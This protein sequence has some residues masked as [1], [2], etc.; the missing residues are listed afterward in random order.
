VPFT[1]CLDVTLH[2]AAVPTAAKAALRLQAEFIELARDPHRWTF[3]YVSA[4]IEGDTL[5]VRALLLEP[6]ED[7]YDAAP[8]PDGELPAADVL[9]G[10]LNANCPTWRSL[11][12]GR[13]HVGSTVRRVRRRYWTDGAVPV[14]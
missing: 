2:V 10:L 4:D 13:R 7:L 1:P 14:R 3:R 12:V 5:I 6:I 11:E 9:L 8:S